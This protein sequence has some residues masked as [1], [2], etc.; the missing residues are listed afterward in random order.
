[1]NASIQR[2]IRI[3]APPANPVA[4]GSPT[5]WLQVE[6]T[7]GLQLPQDY[8]EYTSV[9]GA[10]QWADFFGVLN[11]FYKSKHPQEQ[12]YLEWM[13]T[14]IKG[15]D[16]LREQYPQY[17]APFSEYPSLN[18]LLPI[19]YND[20]GGTICWQI[21]GAPDSWRIVCLG[22]KLSDN[23]DEFDTNLTG[24]LA[25]LLTEEISPKTFP[26]DFFPIAKPMFQPYTTE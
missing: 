8:K 11:P 16:K 17:V 6:Q 13:Q 12:G 4:T 1:M 24:F 15:L 21:T 5:D 26:E 14:R 9:Y 7:L 19:G 2:L 3:E 23:Y 18:G 10:G 22:G 20:N 25:S